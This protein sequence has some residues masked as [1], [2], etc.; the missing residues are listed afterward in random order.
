M[1][2]DVNGEIEGLNNGAGFLLYIKNGVMMISWN[3]LKKS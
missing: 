2:G 1:I 3:I